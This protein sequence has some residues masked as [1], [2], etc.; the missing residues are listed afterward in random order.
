MP[1]VTIPDY[2]YGHPKNE[3][4]QFDKWRQEQVD[5]E[6]MTETPRYVQNGSAMRCCLNPSHLF[7]GTQ[8][9]NI[10]DCVAKGR[11]RWNKC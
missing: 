9:D 6:A 7:L 5:N 10:K 4:S 3:D 2:P 11:H 1:R 8:S